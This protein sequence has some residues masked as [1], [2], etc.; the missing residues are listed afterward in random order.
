MKRYL[1]NLSA[2]Y[3]LVAE[4]AQDAVVRAHEYLADEIM[5]GENISGD[6]AEVRPPDPPHDGCPANSCSIW[7]HFAD[8]NPAFCIDGLKGTVI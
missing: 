4:D 7:K 5:A 2:Q 1:V 3:E 6:V 8:E